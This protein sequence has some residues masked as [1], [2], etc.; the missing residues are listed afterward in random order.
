[1]SKH[2]ARSYKYKINHAAV[3]AA[4]NICWICGHPGSQTTDHV[5]P[6]SLLKDDSIANLRPAHGVQ[7]CP[8]CGRKCNT[9]RGTGLKKKRSARPLGSRSW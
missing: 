4:S 5:I 3:L 8:T 1:M 6:R 2:S 9:S 7:G